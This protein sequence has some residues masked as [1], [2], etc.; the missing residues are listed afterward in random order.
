MCKNLYYRGCLQVTKSFASKT[1][2]DS[3]Y[4][5]LQS[6]EACINKYFMS[7]TNKTTSHSYINGSQRKAMRSIIFK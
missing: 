4:D 3:S 5:A 2:V 7:E 6:K 1:D